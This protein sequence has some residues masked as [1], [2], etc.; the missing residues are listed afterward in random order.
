MD[1]QPHH[2]IVTDRIP[3]GGAAPDRDDVAEP[4]TSSL[5]EQIGRLAKDAHLTVAVAESLTSGLLASRLGK[6]QDASEWFAGGVVAYSD[7]VKQ[8]VLGVAPGPVV[9]ARCA[10][11]MANGAA[12]VAAADIAISTT[13]VG[14]P[15]PAEGHPA[16]TVYPGWECA[17]ES[18]SDPHGFDGDPSAVL[19]Q[20]IGAALTLLLDTIAARGATSN[21]T[22]C[23][24]PGSMNVTLTR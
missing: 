12:R 23:A 22:G 21:E 6:G 18:G 19:E 15:E 7:H 16:G 10:E 13:G 5:V 20:T 14:G 24:P 9:S 3:T 2:T 1:R 8:S 11:Q 4:D 17:D